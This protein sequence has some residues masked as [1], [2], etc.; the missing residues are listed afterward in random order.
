MHGLP[1]PAELFGVAYRLGRDAKGD[2]EA[3]LDG[4]LRGASTGELVAL[5]AAARTSFSRGLWAEHVPLNAPID[6]ARLTSVAPHATVAVAAL[7]TLHRSGFMRELGLRE[8]STTH[9]PLA[10]PFLLL[11]A[12]DIVDGLRELAV[13]EILARLTPSFDA[14][15]ARCLGIL[16]LLRGRTRGAGGPLVKAVHAFLAHPVHREALAAACFGDDPGVRRAAFT[17]R[18]RNEPVVGV[19]EGALS[20]R[21][22][23]IRGWAARL[24]VSR[25]LTDDDKRALLPLLDASSSAFK[26]M[27]ALR[28]HQQ[29]GDPDATLD[30][31]LLDPH[32]SVRHDARRLLKAR[33]PD[34][35]YGEARKEALAV[36]TNTAEANPSAARL[37]GALGALADVGLQV[38]HDVVRPFTS[39]ARPRVR[40]EAKRTLALLDA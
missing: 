18:L 22:T 16:E 33:H 8:L 24:S 29:L 38:D 7:L 3:L 37:V 10:V 31:A 15:F 23:A 13:T 14:A 5:A 40:A 9:D 20:D 4:W 26:R 27:L 6:P 39:D 35:A 2:E 36:L 12:D 25:A 34:R 21:D 30:A 1:A 11:R 32:T 17:L 28:A 19:L